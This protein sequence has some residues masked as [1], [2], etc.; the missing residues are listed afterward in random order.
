MH[1][2]TSE[3]INE[4]SNDLNVRKLDTTHKIAGVDK[5]TIRRPIT[6]IQNPVMVTAEIDQP[7]NSLAIIAE[8][9]TTT[10]GI[11]DQENLT[12]KIKKK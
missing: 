11:A 2:R 8:N 7:R 1:I 9:R 12:T 3:S 4:I 5:N 10:L 6:V